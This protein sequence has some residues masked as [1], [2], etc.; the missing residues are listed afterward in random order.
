MSQELIYTAAPQG[1]K[2]GSRGFCTVAATAGMQASLVERL[3]ALSAYRH[4][5]PPNDPKEPQNPVSHSHL[6]LTIDGRRR[7]VLSRISAAGLSYTQRANLFAH[8]LVLDTVE[9]PAGGP[10]W[11]LSQP[12]V[13]ESAWK[14]DPQ[15]LPPSRKAFVGDTSAAVCRKWQ[16][17]TGDAGWGG[18][19]AESATKHDGAGALVVYRPGM[20]VLPLVAESLALLP[21]DERWD[22]TFS[23]YYTK[24]PPGIECRWRF[25]LEDS[26]EAMAHHSS[27]ITVI[28]LCSPL[29]AP[30]E[31][32]WV[33]A[34]RTGFPPQLTRAMP[35]ERPGASAELMEIELSQDEAGQQPTREEIF[36]KTL[37]RPIHSRTGQI[38]QTYDGGIPRGPAVTRTIPPAIPPALPVFSSRSDLRHSERSAVPWIIAC[39]AFLLVGSAAV[40]AVVFWKNSGD[41]MTEE[42]AHQQTSPVPLSGPRSKEQVYEPNPKQEQAGNAGQQTEGQATPP[43]DTNTTI[44]GLPDSKVQK[45]PDEHAVDE[46]PS[47]GSSQPGTV[48]PEAEQVESAHRDPLESLRKINAFPLLR[49]PFPNEGAAAGAASY[50]EPQPIGQ[51]W[52]DASALDIAL[53]GLDVLFPKYKATV[54]PIAPTQSDPSVKW[55]V[56]LHKPAMMTESVPSPI[57]DILA[58]NGTLKFVWLPASKSFKDIN[59]IRNAI[60]RI[61]CRG[62]TEPVEIQ[63]RAP[64][65]EKP[66]DCDPKKNGDFSTRCWPNP[67]CPDVDLPDFSLIHLEIPADSTKSL[68]GLVRLDPARTSTKFLLGT[69]PDY[70]MIVEVK[71]QEDNNVLEIGYHTEGDP[72][73]GKLV[74]PK[75][76]K[77][78]IDKSL[79]SSAANQ[80]PRIRQQKLTTD[81]LHEVND[82][83]D[84]VLGIIRPFESQYASSRGPDTQA[85]LMELKN[86]EET[87]TNLKGGISTLHAPLSAFERGK[88]EFTIFA[89]IGQRK[90]LL[91]TATANVNTQ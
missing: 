20:D 14:N 75:L 31:T 67:K 85:N 30:A 22:V 66:L 39:I 68:N 78:K 76:N 2:P 81:L 62:T 21:P 47:R 88:L 86:F 7:H 61:S 53:L 35:T 58:E 34:A 50:L 87:I 83:L 69:E 48:R 1:L 82:K 41:K 8:H 73:N 16:E 40:A 64:I 46:N 15:T 55:R 44:P 12:G 26:H 65:E 24:L 32:P 77:S 19:L 38:A 45:G 37:D 9:T 74:Y 51:F 5:F 27:S 25:V 80:I 59:Q 42:V 33:E 54:E 6:K 49:C 10:A 17:L 60:L 89:E 90:V 11:L 18:V 43:P 70:K 72:Q 57:A 23:T 36:I 91:V 56:S 29:D 28:D 71:I 13:M 4:V 79:K 84:E 63:L 3:E 52:C